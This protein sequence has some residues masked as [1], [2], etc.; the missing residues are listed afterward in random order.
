M[1]VKD[2]KI[3]SDFF[4]NKLGF[5]LHN[6]IT[7]KSPRSERTMFGLPHHLADKT[8]IQLQIIGPENNRDGLLDLIELEG[9]IGEDFS[10]NCIPQNTGILCYR[11]PVINLNNYKEFILKNG[12]TINSFSNH[13]FLAG[14]GFVSIMSVISPDGVRLEFFEELENKLGD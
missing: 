1:V 14:I 12:V 4:V 2:L 5:L 11:F 8:N 3:A 9:I 10:R 6:E 7:F 13:V